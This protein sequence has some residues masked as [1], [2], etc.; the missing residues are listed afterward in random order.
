MFRWQTHRRPL[1]WLL[2]ALGVVAVHAVLS[3]PAAVARG[4]PPM[5]P[6]ELVAPFLAPFAMLLP[7][8][9]DDGRHQP[10]QRVIRILVISA[11]FAFV[12][13]IIEANGHIRP[14]IGHLAG[15]TGILRFHACEVLVNT[16]LFT[17]GA[18]WF[19]LC[20]DRVATDCWNIMRRFSDG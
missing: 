7:A 20:F 16:V 10:V 4:H 1:C 2:T 18:F 8:L 15:I 5:E 3:Y 17:T 6:W 13:A 14:S 11:C 19:F 9:F 12:W